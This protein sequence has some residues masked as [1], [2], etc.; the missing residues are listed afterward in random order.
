MVNHFKFSNGPPHLIW[1]KHFAVVLSNV[2]HFFSVTFKIGSSWWCVCVCFCHSAVFTHIYTHLVYF[3]SG[4]SV[5]IFR[6]LATRLPVYTTKKGHNRMLNPLFRKS[7][8]TFCFCMHKHK[9]TYRVNND[10]GFHSIN[11]NTAVFR[12]DTFETFFLVIFSCLFV[13][14][15]VR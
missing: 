13:C 10:K 12:I 6:V 3:N 8:V 9:H 15:T 7:I 1:A 11:P 2:F 5:L 4:M 14:V